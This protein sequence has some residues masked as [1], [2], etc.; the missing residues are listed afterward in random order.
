MNPPI[1]TQYEEITPLASII[2]A[3]CGT[4][5]VREMIMVG[6]VV[7]N[8]VHAEEF[9]RTISEVIQQDNQFEGVDRLL[10]NRFIW[11]KSLLTET[12]LV[13]LKNVS[14]SIVLT[15]LNILQG[16]GF[17]QAIVRN[18]LRAAVNMA[19]NTMLKCIPILV[20]IN[21]IDFND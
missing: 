3:E 1:I 6:L 21:D 4:C 19:D 20:F 10:N 2:N 5:E 11:L 16:G 14:E 18:D 8:R 17:V 13:H 9:P 12:D 15:N 7:L